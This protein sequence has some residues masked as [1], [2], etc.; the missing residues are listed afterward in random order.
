MDWLGP[1]SKTSRN[2]II[3]F[4]LGVI[5]FAAMGAGQ[6]LYQQH[7]L[8]SDGFVEADHID[9]HLINPWGIAFGPTSPAW[10]ANNGTGTSS[11]F[12]GEGN[13]S[14]L[15]VTIPASP[16]VGGIG[17]PT[18]IVSNNTT[19]W[20]VSSNGKSGP[21][22]FIFA[23]EDG[24]ISGWAPSVNATNA[25]IAVDNSTNGAN[26]KGLT[27]GA[28]GEKTLL[29]A[30]NFFSGKVDVFDNQFHPVTL[31]GT[32]TDPYLPAG[33]APYGIQNINGDIYVTFAKQDDAKHDAVN[34]KG[35]GIV[36]VF[37]ANGHFLRRIATGG[38]LNAPWGIALAPAS[39]G[40]FGS[41]LLIGNFGDGKINA[42][43]TVRNQFRG[44]L[45]GPDGHSISI[46]G[47]WGLSFGDGSVNQPTNV[48]YFTAGPVDE[49]HGV[50]GTIKAID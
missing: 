45:H 25:I 9:P 48:L 1:V 27:R 17:K 10:V 5:P 47:L 6:T 20:P 18:G 32:F 19:G 24:T 12:D 8:A 50:Y 33:Y 13:A 21:A 42:Y 34:G 26:Y 39:F 16:T 30:A 49:T 4:A 43:D 14:S 36:D 28:N 3:G 40:S 38:A 37:D 41:H 11:I 2:M 35:L 15:V 46:E 7:N 22:I 29:Y 44:Q 31:T 23:T